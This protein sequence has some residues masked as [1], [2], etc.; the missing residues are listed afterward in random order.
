MLWFT[1]LLLLSILLATILKCNT[2]LYYTVLLYISY[3]DSTYILIHISAQLS[4]D[5]IC[6]LWIDTSVVISLVTLPT[7]GQV[8]LLHSFSDEA[9][10]L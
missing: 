3:N 4:L 1:S 5:L 10:I 7:F 8:L 6:M 9:M 2:V